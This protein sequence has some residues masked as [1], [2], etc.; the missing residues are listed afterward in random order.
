MTIKK[1]LQLWLQKMALED[2]KKI[3]ET[4]KDE[5]IETYRP[6]IGLCASN[7]FKI[8]GKK[9]KKNIKKGFPIF[10]EFVSNH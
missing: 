3:N 2:Q 4:F 8:I 1:L 7:Y 5:N 6:K 10:K 9:S